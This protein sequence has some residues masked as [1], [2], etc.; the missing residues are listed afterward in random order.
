MQS[1]IFYLCLQS[2]QCVNIVFM[3]TTQTHHDTNIDPLILDALHAFLEK[4]IKPHITD[5]EQ[6]G[7]HRETWLQMGDMGLLGIQAP[8]AYGGLALDYQDLATVLATVSSTYPSLG[9][10]LIAHSHLCMHLIQAHGNKKQCLA[11][12]PQL[13]TGESIGAIGISEPNAGS[14]ALSMQ[15]KAI[16]KDNQ[17]YIHGEKTWITNGP[18]ADVGV[19]YAKDAGGNINPYIVDL[20]HP[21]VTKSAPFNKLGMRG[22]KTGSLYFDGVPVEQHNKITASCSGKAILMQ[23][24]NLERVM[25]SAGPIGI[26]AACLQHALSYAHERK[27]FKTRL[28]DFQLIQQKIANMYTRLE[29]SRAMLKEA[30][31][32]LDAQNLDN[33]YAASVY[34]HCGQS[35]VK[36]SNDAL[37]IFG[38]NGYTSDYPV[39]MFYR[40][41][42]LSDIGGGTN[43]IRQ[44]VIAK[45]LMKDFS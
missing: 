25:L 33:A 34:L 2:T 44:L 14:D 11:W 27:Q 17:Y 37:Q 20:N 43:E 29:S 3:A 36:T 45:S 13:I 41:A 16:F 24:L 4:N 18:D 32:R 7:I 6:N 15:T 23:S 8:A 35:A 28:I 5:F 10:S 38:G 39:E 30:F 12:L 26:Q 31:R 22:S 19:I 9:L 42:K 40:D 1:S 21:N